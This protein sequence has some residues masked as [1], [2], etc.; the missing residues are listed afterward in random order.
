M[1]AY[2]DVFDQASM[3]RLASGPR[4]L[5]VTWTREPERILDDANWVRR[6]RWFPDAEQH[7]RQRPD[8]HVADGRADQPALI[9][10]D[11]RS[12]AP[13]WVYTYAELL[14]RDRPAHACCAAS[15]WAKAIRWSSTRLMIPEGHL[16]AGPRPT[17]VPCIRW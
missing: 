5:A 3:I 7:V 15:V 10:A 14:R 13:N 2:H 1:G 16:D 4:P 8:R 12:P 6:P 17:S 11:S 9:Y